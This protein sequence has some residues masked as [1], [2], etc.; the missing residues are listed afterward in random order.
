L[1]GRCEYENGVSCNV[2]SQLVKAIIGIM[3][4]KSF[5]IKDLIGE[6]IHSGKKFVD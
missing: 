5:L 3:S 1:Y 6:E 2:K 4:T